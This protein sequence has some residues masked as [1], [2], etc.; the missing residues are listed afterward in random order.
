MTLQEMIA[1]QRQITE[2][3]RSEGRSLTAEEQREFD[4]LQGQI[5][6]AVAGEARGGSGAGFIQGQAGG[7]QEG[8]AA[9]SGRSAEGAGGTPQALSADP[10]GAG[11]NGNGD[12]QRAILAERTRIRE[13]TALCQR[14]GIE[15][16]QFIARGDT[17]DQVRAAVLSQLERN[18][19]PISARVTE[20]AA[21]KMRSAMVDGILLRTFVVHLCG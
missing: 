8:G 7:G 3:A 15:P 6:A 18:G 14:F 19:A 13:I 21:D 17:M 11:G 12:G 16:E 5:D 2:A 10:A 9:G 1:R 20:D 4:Q